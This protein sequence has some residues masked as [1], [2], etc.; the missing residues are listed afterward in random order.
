MA[1]PTEHLLIVTALARGGERLDLPL[2]LEREDPPIDAL[3]RAAPPGELW[4][5][6]GEPTLRSDLP[7][8]LSALAPGRR[9]GLV[10]DSLALASPSAV[11]ALRRAGLSRVRVALHSVRPDAHDWL[12]GRLGA[13]KRALRALRV[14]REAGL[15]LE[16][17]ATLTRS[18]APYVDEL[19]DIARRLGV[20]A[21]HLRLL[22]PRG[23]A[24]QSYAALAPRLGLLERPLLATA[25]R[26]GGVALS[27]RGFAP[28]TLPPPLRGRRV[29]VRGFAPAGWDEIGALV[30]AP[31]GPLRCADCGEGCPGLPQGYIDRFGVA[32]LEPAE[33]GPR[34]WERVVFGVDPPEPGRDIRRRL[35]RLAGSGAQGALLRGPRS[36]HHPEA[37]ELLREATRLGLPVDV[38]CDLAPLAH[39]SDDQL[40]RVRK[41]RRFTALWRGGEE[42][43]VLERLAELAPGAER[44]ALLVVRGARDLALGDEL[45]VPAVVRLHPDGGE[46]RSLVG[47]APRAALLD[48]LPPCLLDPSAERTRPRSPRRAFGVDGAAGFEPSPLDPEGEF[49]PCERAGECAAA[50][51]CPG[52]A[53]GWSFEGE[54]L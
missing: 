6:G 35:A 36:L 17:V 30:E 23:G 50:G 21:L 49:R 25:R 18:T 51:R 3:V 13:A 10:T 16:I 4:L 14:C 11:A 29:V 19:A 37:P 22:T 52:V 20:E 43:R 44:R 32:E 2:A 46:L 24:A 8:L 53:V 5:G 7:R 41:V 39:W 12:V 31:G 45:P 40:H 48:V 27:L 33:A 9:L 1:T 15:A 34:G 42:R 26:C 28:C 47:G 38:A 54:P